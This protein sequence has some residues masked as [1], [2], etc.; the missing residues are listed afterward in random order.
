MILAGVGIGEYMS[1]RISL[2]RGPTAEVL[3]MVLDTFVIEA[4]NICRNR[5]GGGARG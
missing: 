4:N 1:L 5:D 2:R 3:N